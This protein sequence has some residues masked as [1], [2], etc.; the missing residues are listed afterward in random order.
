V[1]EP[2]VVAPLVEV[3]P[4]EVDE[5]PEVEPEEVSEA[6][7]PEVLEPPQ[8]LRVRTTSDNRTRRQGRGAG[9]IIGWQ[10]E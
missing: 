6:A 2:V 8:A 3:P 7:V 10:M 4:V 5:A 1:V 9:L